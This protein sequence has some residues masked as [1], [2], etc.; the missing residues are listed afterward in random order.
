MI[1]GA[2]G[3]LDHDAVVALVEGQFGLVGRTPEPVLVPARYAG[4]DRR[5]TRALE[6]VHLVLGFDGVGYHDPDY[7]PMAVASMILGGGMSSRLFQEIRENRGLVY[8]IY[9]FSS[10]YLDGGLFGIYAGTGEDGLAELLPVLCDELGRATAD[11]HPDELARAKA[12]LRAGMVMSLES[13]AARAEQLARQV[14][15]Y[16]RPLAMEEMIAR[17]DAVDRAAVEGVI[18]RLLRSAPTVAAVGPIGGLEEYDAIAARVRQ[19]A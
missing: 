17:V 8:S 11:I 18:A 9:S 13:T 4:G 3:K 1:F 6:Q 14:S 7:Y 12:Q 2:A 19:A 10:A 16:D 15:I 5:E